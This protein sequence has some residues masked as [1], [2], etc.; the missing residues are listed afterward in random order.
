MQRETRSAVHLALLDL[1]PDAELAAAAVEQVDLV[2][3]RLSRSCRAQDARLHMNAVL[4]AQVAL[5]P[6]GDC[7]A[8]ERSGAARDSFD[9]K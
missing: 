8:A 5:F 1:N 9:A 7:T 4:V 3:F 2:L 6:P